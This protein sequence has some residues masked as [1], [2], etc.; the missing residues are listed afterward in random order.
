MKILRRLMAVFSVSGI[1]V[2]VGCAG[3][4]ENTGQVPSY[5]LT[6]TDNTAF[7]YAANKKLAAHPGK[8]GFVL[9]PNGLDA[10]VARARLARHAERSLD[11]QYYLFHGDLTGRLFLNELVKAAERG[12]RIRFLIDDWALSGKDRS[13]AVLDA[14]PNIEVRVFNPFNREGSRSLQLVGRLGKVTRRMHNKSFTADNQITI[15]GGRNIGNEYFDA[16]PDMA[17]SDLDTMAIGPIVKQVSRSFDEYWNSELAYPVKAIISEPTNPEEAKALRKKLDDFIAENADSPYLNSLRESDLS[18]QIQQK[19]VHWYWGKADALYDRPEKLL[20]DKGKTELLMATQLSPIMK[21]T[22]K[23]LIIFSPYFVPTNS[24]VASLSALVERGVRVRVLTNSLAATDVGMVHSGYSKYR[25]DLLRNGIE[26]YE[27]DKKLNK[28]QRKEK[29][30]QEGRKKASLHTKS[31]ILDRNK[32]FIGSLNLD[33]RS[34][35]ENTEIGIVLTS[36]EMAVEM[37]T[38]FDENIDKVAFRLELE[39]DADGYERIL[40]HAPKGDPKGV[41]IVD[42]HTGFWR[43][44]GLEFLSVFPIDSQL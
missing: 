13:L 2:I 34:F 30:G 4:P 3:M 35:Y 31:F 24:G 20:Y 23:E 22:Q 19:T 7:G 38:W 17:F 6:D 33:P 14:I 27:L 11:V 42:P 25:H 44:F 5:A 26:L 36:Q 41:Y 8:S 21:D 9:L 10:F 37:A 18:K 15:V 39:I 29:K 16:D 28:R 32:V 40:W 1:L 43:R 12:V